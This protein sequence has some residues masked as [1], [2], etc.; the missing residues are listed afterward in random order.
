MD[1]RGLL[2]S[3]PACGLVAFVP[4]T[5]VAMSPEAS[6][7]LRGL[8]EVHRQTWIRFVSALDAEDESRLRHEERLDLKEE[9]DN[10]SKAET[11]ALDAI[12]SYRCVSMAGIS[13]KA[14][15]IAKALD[16]CV[17]DEWQTGLLVDS[18]RE[19]V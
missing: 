2:K 12:L 3:I 7:E 15:Y 11:V 1:R 17:M 16:G 9:R 14:D 10:A 18:M 19:I 13:M 6:S 4:T 8:I 5:A